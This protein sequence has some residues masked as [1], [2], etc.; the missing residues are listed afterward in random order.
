MNDLSPTNTDSQPSNGHV[1]VDSNYATRVQLAVRTTLIWAGLV[2]I[3][4]LTKEFFLL[5]FAAILLAVFLSEG[6]SLLEHYFGTTRKWGL[7]IV[8]IL[9]LTFVIIGLW[10]GGQMLI[11]QSREAITAIRGNAIQWEKR[12]GEMGLPISLKDLAPSPGGQSLGF[13]KAFFSS[14]LG[15]FTNTLFVAVVGVFLASSPNTYRQGIASLWPADQRE[16]VVKLLQMSGSTLKDWLFGQLFAMSIIGLVVGVSLGILGVPAAFALGLFAGA[17]SF[18]PTIGATLA[19]IPALIMAAQQGSWTVIAVLLIYGVAQF[20]ESNIATPLI[21]NR[22]VNLTA[23]AILGGQ[24]FAGL[25]FGFLGVALITP[26]LA[27]AQLWLQ[28]LYLPAREKNIPI[29][30]YAYEAL[31]QPRLLDEPS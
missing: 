18:I 1:R 30:Q 3:V 20:F 23:A 13:A 10:V 28:L 8:V 25:L 31:R 17:V 6:A 26:F 7:S 22:Q 29:R 19:I 16:G 27:V 11:E 15:F 14:T 2:A 24:L 12:I 9:L 4:V 21:Q 5:M